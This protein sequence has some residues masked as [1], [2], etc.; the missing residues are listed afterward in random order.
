MREAAQEL[1]FELAAL[2]RDEIKTLKKQ[3]KI[4]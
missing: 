2:L 3:I 4:Q 1:N